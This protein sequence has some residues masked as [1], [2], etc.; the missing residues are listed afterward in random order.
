MRCPDPLGIAK[1]VNSYRNH[2]QRLYLKHPDPIQ[3]R[4]KKY[5]EPAIKCVKWSK[6]PADKKRKTSKTATQFF[7]C[8]I[9]YNKFNK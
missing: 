1:Y 3:Y 4:K 8:Q 7:K 6:E 9:K 2:Y 5:I